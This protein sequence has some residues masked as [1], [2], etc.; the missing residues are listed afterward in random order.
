MARR[1]REE[2]EGGLYHVYARGNGRQRIFLDDRD[3]STYLF[4]LQSVAKRQQ[5]RVLSYCLMDNHIHLL[6]ETP[7]ANLARGMQR[8]HGTYAQIFNERHETVGHLFQGRYGAV[9]IKDDEQ[10]W[11]VVGYIA[12]NP[13]RAGFCTAPEDW[14]WSSHREILGR[15]APGLL[16]VQRLLDY[17]AAAGGDPL[18]RYMAL[19]VAAAA[20][21]GSDPLSE[22]DSRGLT[23]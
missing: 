13:V 19:V 9:R 15:R 11:T 7:H 1:P 20:G 3:R 14:S 2:V 12:A 21:A 22:G 16:E 5:W 23:P 18:E 10:L 6:V 8:L 17:L 4:L